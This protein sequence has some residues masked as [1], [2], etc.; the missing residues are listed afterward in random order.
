MVS[1]TTLT[2]LQDV[3][4]VKRQAAAQQDLGCGSAEAKA[5]ALFRKMN[6]LVAATVRQ[7]V[8]A[9]ASA[10]FARKTFI[11]LIVLVFVHRKN[12]LTFSPAEES[13]YTWAVPLAVVVP[14]CNDVTSMSADTLLG[15]VCVSADSGIRVQ[16]AG[17]VM[18][19]TKVV[20]L[21]LLGF[22]PVVYKARVFTKNMDHN[23][24]ATNGMTFTACAA[25]AV[26]ATV[27]QTTLAIVRAVIGIK[28]HVW[29]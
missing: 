17:A 3:V 14:N 27:L 15:E 22:K 1:H 8:A 25:V 10:I 12:V 28:V 29:P 9:A 5:A 19:T 13:P 2:I 24:N 7:Q 18:T 16:E 20:I 26:K 11:R 21:D 4:V 23:L 6:T